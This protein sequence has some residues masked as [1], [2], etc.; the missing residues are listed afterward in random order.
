VKEAAATFR[1]RLKQL[2][3]S[4]SAISAAWPEWWSEAADAS[5]SAQAELRFTVA[6]KLGLDPRSLVDDA[7]PRFTWDES[8]KYKNFTGVPGDRPAIASF[9]TALANLLLA[10]TPS[11]TA[12]I[13]GISAQELRAALL[14]QGRPFVELRDLMALA[15]GLGSPVIHLR[16]YP[17]AAK[18]M[19][20]MSA[21]IHDR[22]AILL[23]RDAAYP[24]PIAFHLAHEIAH[25]ALGH[26][27]DGSAIIDMTDPTDA[28]DA[29]QVDSEEAA[30][31]AY[32]LELL[33]GQ[34]KPQIVVQG[35]GRSARELAREAV[36][37]G[38]K[39][40]IEPG[41]L[42][43]CAG[44][45]SHDWQLAHAALHYIYSGAQSV[46]EQINGFALRQLQLDRLP[47]E[48]ASYV[49]AVL[50]SPT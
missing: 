7:E 28:S 30:A 41:T 44:F 8:V 40:H 47:E 11:S 39:H 48:S 45:V 9:G 33:T 21:M 46:W 16:V 36:I 12:S 49:R 32:A 24:A 42:A 22:F 6:R 35:P 38:A 27:R 50:G 37:A 5:A 18:R 23:A 26:V 19:C 10:A 17:L 15:W 31:D 29:G 25:V 2:G 43:L 20:A 1:R 13:L 14:A 4:E 3:L 34:A